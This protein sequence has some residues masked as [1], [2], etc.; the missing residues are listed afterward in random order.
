MTTQPN[1]PEQDAEIEALISETLWILDQDRNEINRNVLRQ[2]LQKASAL[3]DQ[4]GAGAAA[5]ISAG[6]A[7]ADVSTERRRLLWRVAKAKFISNA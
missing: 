5:L 3:R 1:Q 2:M 7:M 6:D 4:R